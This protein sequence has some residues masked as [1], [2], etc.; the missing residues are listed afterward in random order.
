[1]KVAAVSAHFGR[2]LEQCLSRIE[3]IIDAARTQEVDLLV[4]PDATIGGYLGTFADVDR[5]GLPPS[6]PADVPE[7]TR[8]AAMA[9]TWWSASPTARW[10]ATTTTTPRCA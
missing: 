5:T 1:V 6:L 7:L 9:G 3:V 4:F 8:V 2:D 10:R